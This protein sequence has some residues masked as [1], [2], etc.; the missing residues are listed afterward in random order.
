M[1]HVKKN[2]K[3]PKNACGNVLGYA[4]SHLALLAGKHIVT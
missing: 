1:L 2:R 4:L 3:K